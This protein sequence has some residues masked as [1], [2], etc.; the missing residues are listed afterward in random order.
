MLLYQKSYSRVTIIFITIYTIAISCFL[1]GRLS[2]LP[3]LFI[4]GIIYLII[5]L[6][7]LSRF[8]SLIESG[9]YIGAQVFFID[10]YQIWIILI[11]LAIIILSSIS[12][13]YELKSKRSTSLNIFLISNLILTIILTRTFNLFYF[14]IFCLNFG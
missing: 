3:N 10:F 11:I 9:S 5:R 13:F 4:L 7:T 1:I 2:S 14:F 6:C 8:K 12:A